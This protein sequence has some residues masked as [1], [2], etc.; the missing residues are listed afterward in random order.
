[1]KLEIIGIHT[2][3]RANRL[4][5]LASDEEN[6]VSL[7]GIDIVVLQKEDFVNTIFLERTEFDKEADGA[8][9]RSFDY[10]VFLASHLFACQRFCSRLMLEQHVRFRGAV[11]ALVELCL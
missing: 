6:D 8:G 3:Y 4:R 9:E 2:C 10:Q 11:K 7:A 5:L 1:M